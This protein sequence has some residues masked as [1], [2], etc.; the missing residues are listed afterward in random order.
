M[1]DEVKNTELKDEYTKEHQTS[2]D[3]NRMYKNL[4]SELGGTKN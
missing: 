3:L 2:V 1:D 4:L